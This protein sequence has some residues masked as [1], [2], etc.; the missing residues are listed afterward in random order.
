MLKGSFALRVARLLPLHSAGYVRRAK[1]S[2]PDLGRNRASQEVCCQSRKRG[3]RKE[4]TRPKKGFAR[5]H[6]K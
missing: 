5:F 3:D 1:A 2:A 6:W 4:K